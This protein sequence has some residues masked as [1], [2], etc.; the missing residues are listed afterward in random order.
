MTAETLYNGIR[1]PTDWPPPNRPITYEPM[2]VPYLASPPD[3]I[4]IDVGRQLFVDDFLVE[5]TTLTRRHHKAVYVPGNPV[6]RPDRPWETAAMAF[7]DGVW[8]DPADGLFKVWYLS[9]LSEATCHA[10]SADGIHWD[11]PA[12][13][14]VPGTN[15]VDRGNRDSGTVWL[16]LF[17]SDPARRYKMFYYPWDG[18]HVS[19]GNPYSVFFS[20]DGIHWGARAG[21]TGSTGDRSTVF[22]NPFRKVWVYSI[23]DYAPDG[24]GRYRRYWECKDP[25]AGAKWERGEPGF[26]IG[27]DRLDPS[28]PDLGG[29]APELYN[30]DAVA[31][32]SLMV[33]LFDV[34]YGQPDD[35]A[36]PNELYVGFSR[37]GYHW[38]RPRRK[39]LVGVSERYGDWNWANVQSAGGCLLVV[40]D[41]L[42]FYVSGRSGERGS[43]SSGTCTTG[44]ATLRRD[45][46]TSMGAGREPGEL[47]TRKVRFG[48]E[49]LFVNVDAAGGELAVEVLDAEGRVVPPLTRENC[50]PICVDSTI[51]PITWR[52]SEN[53]SAVAG[54]PV[55]F[56]FHLR[57][58]SL[59]AF[60]VSPDASGASHG[61]VAAGG[62]GL[63]GPLDTVGTAA[64]EV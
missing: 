8:Y 48:G 61:H 43:K 52:G 2:L 31:Y 37:D 41:K 7:S 25:L 20:A 50:E 51:Q 10:T 18:P 11:K 34:W 16:D 44:L 53:L 21:T 42:Y 29:V 17:E 60:W 27:A 49:R 36:K 59:Y 26:W 23:R 57:N 47:T 3:V 33:G 24:I 64:Y 40:R 14:V 13:D 55:R 4:P 22:F 30:L 58:G 54:K 35:R 6:L 63:T 15:I 28:R 38:D 45:G 46:F 1:L 39:P 5:R 9:R 12:L 62:P 19:I 32:E 56:R